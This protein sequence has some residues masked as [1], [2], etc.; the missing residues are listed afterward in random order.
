MFSFFCIIVDNYGSTRSP[1]PLLPPPAFL[2]SPHISLFLTIVLS[3]EEEEK[4]QQCVMKKRFDS[5]ESLNL[6]PCSHKMYEGEQVYLKPLLREFFED[7][8]HDKS[9]MKELQQVIA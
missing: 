6:P 5:L 8:F 1:D 3:A 7:V 4:A 2:I 9:L